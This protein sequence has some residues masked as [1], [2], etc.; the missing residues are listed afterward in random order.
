[1]RGCKWEGLFW[2]L[3]WVGGGELRGA[4]WSEQLAVGKLCN[5]MCEQVKHTLV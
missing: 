5:Q 1:M 4:F 2:V 3:F